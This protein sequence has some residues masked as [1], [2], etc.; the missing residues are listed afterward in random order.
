MLGSRNPTRFGRR[1]RRRK[2]PR[3][4]RQVQ[5]PVPTPPTSPWTTGIA[6]FAGT[7][8][9]GQ[10]PATDYS[11]QS[12]LREATAM[13]LRRRQPDEPA[14]RWRPEQPAKPVH[15]GADITELFPPLGPI[16]AHVKGADI[17]ELFPKPPPPPPMPPLP[18][19][20]LFP[21]P[22]PPP[23]E[24]VSTR[25]GAP[26]SLKSWNRRLRRPLRSRIR[27]QNCRERRLRP[28]G[29][30]HNL[31]SRQGRGGN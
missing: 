26:H 3:P 20:L 11:D 21:K 24:G 25:G 22:P 17:T 23:S 12:L 14:P 28:G 18:P 5:V 27:R 7:R 19:E 16:P 1:F 8:E 9:A 2:P 30:P 15:A 4:L 29:T 6:A 31:K 10:P 13:R